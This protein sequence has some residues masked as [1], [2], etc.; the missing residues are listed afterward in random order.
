MGT[1]SRQGLTTSKT[2]AK[3]DI[4][5]TWM[6]KGPRGNDKWFFVA[7]FGTPLSTWRSIQLSNI[8][9]VLYRTYWDRKNR[10]GDPH[11]T[12]QDQ[13]TILGRTTVSWKYWKFTSKSLS[14]LLE[15]K[16][17][18][19]KVLNTADPSLM[20]SIPDTKLYQNLATQRNQDHDQPIR[21][22][23]K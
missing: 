1:L 5:T 20:T 7:V 12:T 19:L 22:L 13:F 6:G 14:R 15:K 10:P 17:S 4:A 23:K 3:C 21:F 18:I 2:M 11:C 16:N 8:R 9:E